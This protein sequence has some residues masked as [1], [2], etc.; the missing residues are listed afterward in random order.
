MHAG[1][2]AVIALLKMSNPRFLMSTRA[3]SES[4]LHRGDVANFKMFRLIWFVYLA[5]VIDSFLIVSFSYLRSFYCK[6]MPT[7][8]KCNTKLTYIL[9]L[10]QWSLRPVF[11]SINIPHSIPKLVFSETVSKR[12]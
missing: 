7:I 9:K 4:H 8:I 6:L 1:L 2:M 5:T 10:A 11:Q 12:C 3:T